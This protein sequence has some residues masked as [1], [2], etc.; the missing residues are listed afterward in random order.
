MISH[1]HS[2]IKTNRQPSATNQKHQK[3]MKT[4]KKKPNSMKLSWKSWKPI[5]IIKNIE[6]TMKPN[7]KLWQAVNLP[8]EN[9]KVLF[10]VSHRQKVF[11]FRDSRAKKVI[12]MSQGAHFLWITLAPTDLLEKVMIF[13]LTWRTGNWII[14]TFP[15]WKVR[16]CYKWSRLFL[17]LILKLFYMTLELS[18]WC[19]SS[20]PAIWRRRE[21]WPR[22]SRW[23]LQ[24]FSILFKM[25][26]T[27][28]DKFT[29][30]YNIT[31][32]YTP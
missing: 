2:C 25:M 30:C 7:W 21:K 28:K 20:G 16:L 31:K 19:P 8:W 12:L 32:S 22:S 15:F 10:F 27:I 14:Q 4:N 5:K 1:G 29:S 6:T 11:I 24:L 18:C 17:N 23:Y 9:V 13:S 3:T 26:S